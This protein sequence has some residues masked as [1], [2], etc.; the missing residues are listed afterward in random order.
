MKVGVIRADYNGVIRANNHFR[1]VTAT[2]AGECGMCG[3]TAERCDCYLEVGEAAV[4]RAAGI[5]AIAFAR[6]RSGL[7]C[8]APHSSIVIDTSAMRQYTEGVD[9]PPL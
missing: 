1:G 8:D 9:L 7:P 4:R 2:A 6:Y 3:R 5:A